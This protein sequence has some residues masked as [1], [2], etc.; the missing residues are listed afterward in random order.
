MIE[1][2][3]NQRYVIMISKRYYHND[4]KELV[5]FIY[6][7]DFNA[8]RKK[9]DELISADNTIF[10]ADLH[11]YYFDYE[12]FDYQCCAYINLGKFIAMVGDTPITKAIRWGKNGQ[13]YVFEYITERKLNKLIKKYGIDQVCDHT[14]W[15]QQ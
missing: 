6:F 13:K 8:L 1:Q 12:V 11:S 3:K 14:L 7:D 5:K 2:R 10:R 9:Y 15:L 4:N